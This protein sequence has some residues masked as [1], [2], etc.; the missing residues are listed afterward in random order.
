MGPSFTINGDAV[1]WLNWHFRFRLDS[2]VGPVFDLIR[3]QDGPKQRMV[4]YQANFS[5]MYVPYMD[6]A[7]GWNSRSYLDAGE[8]PRDGMLRDVGT[9]DCPSNATFVPGLA[10]SDLGTPILRPREACLFERATGDPAWRHWDGDMLSA[11][12]AASWC[13]VPSPPLATMTTF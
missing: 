8:F 10:F 12:R 3:F 1:S 4:L 9:D 11:V 7:E 13:S 5:E 6:T 2:R